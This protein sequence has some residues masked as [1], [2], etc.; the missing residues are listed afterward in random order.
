MVEQTTKHLGHLPQLDHHVEQVV[1]CGVE[2]RAGL[3]HVT[4]QDGGDQGL[5]Q[6]RVVGVQAG[7]QVLQLRGQLG[8]WELGA[9]T[10]MIVHPGKRAT[11]PEQPIAYAGIVKLP[12]CELLIATQG[13]RM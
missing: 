4:E 1:E 6:V 7:H 2:R 13:G 9:V 8:G 12:M 11:Q 3:L 5:H 10:T